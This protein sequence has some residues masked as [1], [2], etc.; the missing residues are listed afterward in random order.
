M[1]GPLGKILEV[2]RTPITMVEKEAAHR[3]AEVGAIGARGALSEVPMLNALLD[4]KPMEL[5]IGGIVVPIQLR[6][7]Q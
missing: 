6:E 3:I 4:G 5:V 7:K 1:N 2:M